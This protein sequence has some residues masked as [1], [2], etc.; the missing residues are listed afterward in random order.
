MIVFIL[1]LLSVG[2]F[3]IPIY[4]SYSRR[5]SLP[6]LSYKSLQ[7]FFC[8]ELVGSGLTALGLP[9]YFF[10]VSG[11]DSSGLSQY[12]FF[13]LLCRIF[14]LFLLFTV[15]YRSLSVPFF[16]SGMPGLGTDLTK[17]FILIL[18]ALLAW[19]LR[20]DW[21]AVL[22]PRLAYQIYRAGNGPFW[23]F[24]VFITAFFFTHLVL[25]NKLRIRF[26]ILIILLS[27]FTGSKQFILSATFAS[28][29]LCA[30]SDLFV[31]SSLRRYFSVVRPFLYLLI[32][33]IVAILLYLN[34]G[35]FADQPYNKLESYF[36]SCRHATM[37]V[38]DKLQHSFTMP[39]SMYGS[40]FWSY[41]PR[42]IFPEKPFTYGSTL[43]N[44][45]YFQ[46]LAELGATP[47]FG[48]YT[49][50]FVEFGYIGFLLSP[51]D[52]SSLFALLAIY[53]VSRPS[54]YSRNR[55]LSAY[56]FSFLAFPGISFHIFPVVSF[57][58]FV[59]VYSLLRLK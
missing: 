2:T 27:W 9:C 7:I 11:Q 51:F 43:L 50:L 39:G 45:L 18:I 55:L 47:S 23:T 56:A 52:S 36:S 29:Y 34:F 30:S 42:F 14:W 17:I 54:L 16:S 6:S 48:L 33:V 5:A 8:T 24:Y 35:G 40:Q 32:P 38:S 31:N 1:L 41:I 57:L 22:N 20:S 3:I 21:N 58:A 26:I 49:S 44:E 28:V 4:I 37:A 46:G 59:G 13:F 53:V 10:I 19:S 15:F 25:D 12:L